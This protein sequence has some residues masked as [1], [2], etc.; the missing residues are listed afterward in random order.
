MPTTSASKFH[1]SAKGTVEPCEAKVRACPL[2]SEAPHFTSRHAA[3]EYLAFEHEV[4][5]RESAAKRKPQAK[6]TFQ[7]AAPL[8]HQ[9]MTSSQR[10]AREYARLANDGEL[11]VSP[12]YQRGSVWS[13]E[14]RVNLVRSFLLGVPI[15]AIII[16]DR[17]TH[18]WEVRNGSTPMSTGVG[19]YAAIDGKQRLET[20]VAWFNGDLPVPASWFPAEEVEQTVPTADG[21][22]VTYK[23][24]TLTGQRLLAN[25]AMLTVV[26]AQLPS[27]QAEA[28]MYLLVNGAGVAQTDEDYARVQQIADKA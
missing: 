23:G 22:Y 14:Q 12:S 19:I 1:I 9:S 26:E 13:V 17:G 24:L 27:E 11:D 5:V 20:T 8:S 18:A 25:R 7:T 3:D 10:S 2:G 6:T 15:P 4:A 16:N 21:P 28:N